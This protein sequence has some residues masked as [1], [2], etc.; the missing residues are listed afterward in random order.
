MH[1]GRRA[2]QVVTL[3][4]TRPPWVAPF[5]PETWAEAWYPILPSFGTQQKKKG[6]PY[7][8]SLSPQSTTV[9]SEKTA[10]AQA[11]VSW[12]KRRICQTAG[13]CIIKPEARAAGYILMGGMCSFLIVLFM[14]IRPIRAGVSPLIQSPCSTCFIVRWRGMKPKT[15]AASSSRTPTPRSRTAL[16]GAIWHRR[17]PKWAAYPPRSR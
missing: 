12:E 2:L 10:P 3:K 16:S 5:I 14:A 1:R 4:T 8:L 17:S 7:E 9:R 6:A 13:F 11:V 15:M